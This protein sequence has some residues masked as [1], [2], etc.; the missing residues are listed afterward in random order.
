MS[1]NLGSKLN[2]TTMEFVERCLSCEGKIGKCPDYFKT[3]GYNICMWRKT[4]ETDRKKFFD[5]RTD[6]TFEEV[7]QLIENQY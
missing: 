5:G 2:L 4:M 6:L 1:E 7:R 3:N